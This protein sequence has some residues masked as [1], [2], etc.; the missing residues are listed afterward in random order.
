MVA[1]DF[2]STRAT[3]LT[4]SN[5][6]A[7]M[8]NSEG[9]LT[10]CFLPVISPSGWGSYGAFSR[11]KLA[12]TGKGMLVAFESESS[13][14]ADLTTPAEGCHPPDSSSHGS[15]RRFKPCCAHSSFPVGS[16]RAWTISP[17]CP[18]GRLGAGGGQVSTGVVA[19]LIEADAHRGAGEPTER[20]TASPFVGY[21]IPD[22][23]FAVSTPHPVG[24]HSGTPK[25]NK[26]PRHIRASLRIIAEIERRRCAS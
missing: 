1:E 13:N 16:R 19:A 9:T 26:P 18:R 25:A 24:R 5:A 4:V 6:G 14:C 23:T 21:Q 20:A 3:S 15:G 10:P 8:G 12:K 22:L 2:R 7:P 17:D 11:E